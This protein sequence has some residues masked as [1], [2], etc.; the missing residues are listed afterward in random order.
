[1]NT[2]GASSIVGNVGVTVGSTAFT[3][4]GASSQTLS[5]TATDYT[6]VGSGTGNLTISWAQTS[7]KALYIKSI[8]FIDLKII[9]KPPY[10]RVVFVCKNLLNIHRPYDM[11]K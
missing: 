5:A 4:S 2:S 8:E 3:S 10:F 6:F 9:Q 11:L 1:V 7:S